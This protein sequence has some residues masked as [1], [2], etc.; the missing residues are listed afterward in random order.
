MARWFEDA[1]IAVCSM[2]PR[3]PGVAA[4]FDGLDVLLVGSDIADMGKREG[5]DLA[6]IGGI[7]EDLLVPGHGGIEA[8]LADRMAGRAEA[9][10]SST[11]PSASTRRAVSFGSVQDS[12][13]RLSL[14]AHVCR[15]SPV[16]EG[17]NLEPRQRLSVRVSARLTELGAMLGADLR[18]AI[19]VLRDE[20]N[21]ALK[22]AMKAR[23]KRRVSTLRLVNAALKNADIEA[24]GQGKQVLAD[25][26]AASACC[27]R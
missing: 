5:D 26:E 24:R 9:D 14:M 18:K 19:A 12:C 20:I 7:G 13:G 16:I 11:V 3:A 25:D 10:P 15:L 6:R 17:L 21:T 22:D 4:M 23:D 1:V 2:M 27:R 8:H